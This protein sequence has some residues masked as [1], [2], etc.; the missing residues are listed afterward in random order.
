[1][2]NGKSIC[3]IALFALIT[4]GL[5]GAE[6][7]KKK[8]SDADK[9]FSQPQVL[10]LKIEI[11]SAS[12]ARLK[13]NSKKYVEGIVREGESVSLPAG[14]RLKGN[15]SFQPLEKK[16]SLSVKFNEF[17]PGTRFHGQTKILLNNSLRDPT[18]LCEAVGGEIFRDA[19]VP[20]ARVVHARIE[21]NGRDLGFYL[22]AEAANKDFLSRHFKDG[23]GH[24]YEGL[25]A[26]VNETLEQDAG[27]M[28]DDQSD[29]KALAAAAAESDPALRLKKLSAVLDL[30][31]FISFLAAEVFTGHREGYSMGKTDYR[32][33]HDPTTGLMV[34]LPH[35]LDGL[36]ERPTDP[37][38]PEWKGLVAR[39]VMETPDGQRR[40]RERM[41]ALLATA[42]DA[43]TLQKR[44]DE[45]VQVIRTEAKSDAGRGWTF[46]DAVKQLRERVGLRCKFVAAELGKLK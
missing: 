19:G 3:A 25:N 45:L 31:R 28:S 43:E 21:L 18:S 46:D 40:Y 16:P 2:T 11:P 9:F 35:G 34:F 33:Y 38:L 39:A 6:A 17:V 44:I 30:D 36:F 8:S 22:L 12:T 24:L 37:L 10:H 27:D 20:A 42:F 4:P 29:L 13:L 14:I 26:D 15:D 23:K 1:M 32:V 5:D 7:V 41:S